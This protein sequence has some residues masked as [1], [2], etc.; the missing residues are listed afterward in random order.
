LW[1]LTKWGRAGFLI[2]TG[3]GIAIDSWLVRNGGPVVFWPATGCDL[4]VEIANV[5]HFESLRAR[6]SNEFFEGAYY[7]RL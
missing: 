1:V 2:V 3:W 7:R 5:N 6:M 4:I